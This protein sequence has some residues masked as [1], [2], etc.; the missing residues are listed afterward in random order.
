[1]NNNNN[2]NNNKQKTKIGEPR[3]HAMNVRQ[4]KI[5]NYSTV[6]SEPQRHFV[7]IKSV[8]FKLITEKKIKAENGATP[9]PSNKVSAVRCHHTTEFEIMEH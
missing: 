9:K 8:S 1:M 6:V 2:N 4:S 5:K 3:I 7:V